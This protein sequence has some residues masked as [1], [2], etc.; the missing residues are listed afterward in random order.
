MCANVEPADEIVYAPT[1][2]FIEVQRCFGLRYLNG[3]V[4][5]RWPV[6]EQTRNPCQDQFCLAISLEPLNEIEP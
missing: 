1:S 4:G 5:E 3:V 2:E 6:I